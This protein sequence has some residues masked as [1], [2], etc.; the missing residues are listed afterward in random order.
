MRYFPRFAVL[1]AVVAGLLWWAPWRDR[2]DALMT[3]DDLRLHRVDGYR[4][5]YPES[6]QVRSGTNQDGLGY[7][8][9]NGPATSDGAHSGQVRVVRQDAWGHRLQDK[10][11][12]F[13]VAASATGRD[14]TRDEPVSVQGAQAAH[15]FDM[16][17]R[18]TTPKG[19]SVRLHETE[20]FV[21]SDEAMLLDITARAPLEGTEPDWLP[22]V[23]ESLRVDRQ[24]WF[25]LR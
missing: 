7:V 15:R 3:A 11:A 22:R 8:E 10:L 19:V 6:W 25:L 21:L 14:V 5:A 1:V 4:L 23:L 17:T 9:F 16:V 24:G 20:M 13:R 12:Q 18:E 2:I